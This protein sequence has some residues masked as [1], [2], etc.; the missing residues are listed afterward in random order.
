M[1][2][3]ESKA[4]NMRTLRKA[5]APGAWAKHLWHPVGFVSLCAGT[6]C[7]LACANESSGRKT[8]LVQASPTTNNTAGAAPLVI[9]SVSQNLPTGSGNSAGTT[10][11]GGTLPIEGTTTT[12]TTGATAGTTTGATTG[13][14]TGGTPATGAMPAA[15][16]DCSKTPGEATNTGPRF[17]KVSNLPLYPTQA[18]ATAGTGALAK[19]PY[20]TQVMFHWGV[21]GWACVT[22]SGKTPAVTGWVD[23]KTSLGTAKP[24]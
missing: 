12:T 21:N 23:A 16:A 6:L 24:K 14:T 3:H 4:T 10:P 2:N 17:A 1:T 9:P 7:V 8:P 11:L 5:P 18:D 20:A 15:P 19:L 22:W 13:T